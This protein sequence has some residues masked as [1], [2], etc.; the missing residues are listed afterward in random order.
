M[1]SQLE[2]KDKDIVVP[3]M[4]VAKGMDFLPNS[5]TYRSGTVVRASKL[6]IISIDGRVLRVIP[7]SGRYSPRKG[8][9][10]IGKITDITMGGWQ[11]NTNSAYGAMISLQDASSD[12]IRRGSDLTQY[13]QIGDAV[14]TK[15]YNVTSQKLIDLTMKGSGLQ[16]LQGGRLLHVSP[17]KVSRIIGKQG[18]M[19]T[20][21][22]QSTGCKIIIGQNGVVWI[23]GNDPL[24]EIMAVKSIEMVE[25]NSHVTNLTEKVR[26]YLTSNSGE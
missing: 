15:I 16:K 20:L 7:L 5:G 8:D 19:V 18:S 13:F 9:V 6:G 3:G 25:R 2:V 24:S 21:I 26:K 14:V 22:K 12:Y 11:V 17:S 1:D 23:K 10:I 4:I